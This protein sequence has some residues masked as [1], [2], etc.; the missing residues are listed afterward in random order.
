MGE[1]E[2]SIPP[3]SKL[4][5]SLPMTNIQNQYVVI[6]NYNNYGGGGYPPVPTQIPPRVPMPPPGMGMAEQPYVYS[7][8]QP[9]LAPQ[10]MPPPPPY[11]YQYPQAYPM[12]PPQPYYGFK[13]EA[14]EELKEAVLE[15]DVEKLLGKIDTAVRDQ[16]MCRL[17]QKKLEE[18][19]KEFAAKVFVQL[20]NNIGAYMNDPF[21][22]YLCQKL[23]DYCSPDQLGQAVD[24]I[25]GGVM[26]IATNLH[27]TRAIQKVIE[28][29]VAWPQLVG[30]IVRM[31]QGHITALVM[32]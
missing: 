7:M 26:A 28:K 8:Y 14:K 19:D 2:S 25:S 15:V 16:T 21:G 27:G 4:P 10:Y 17:L 32:V 6:N 1:C 23:F 24:S 30:R 13:H 9:Q 3:L 12:V 31:L 18:G 20:I 5:Q 11:Y 22:N 29:A